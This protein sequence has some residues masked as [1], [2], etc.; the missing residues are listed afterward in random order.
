MNS[1]SGV[2]GGRAE[3]F[4]IVKEVARVC[5]DDANLFLADATYAAYVNLQAA[6]R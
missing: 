5:E 2:V 3:G 4:G 1:Y 6:R